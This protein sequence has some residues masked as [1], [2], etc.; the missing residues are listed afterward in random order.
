MKATILILTF[1]FSGAYLF[2]QESNST[3]KEVTINVPTIKC[4]SCVKTV[5]S[6]LKKLDGIQI[7]NVDKKAKIAVIRFDQT[8]LKLADIEQAIAKSGYDANAMKRDTS[9]YDE[10]DACCR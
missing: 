6:A 3:V 4:G 2:S 7:V 1:L 8:K 9:A 10:L 5:T